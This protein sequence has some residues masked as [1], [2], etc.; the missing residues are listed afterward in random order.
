MNTISEHRYILQCKE[1]EP[2]SI[3]K[4]TSRGILSLAVL[5]FQESYFCHLK[6]KNV[7]IK[8]IV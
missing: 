7:S 8:M 5:H 1:D 3:L 6:E 4:G 2:Q